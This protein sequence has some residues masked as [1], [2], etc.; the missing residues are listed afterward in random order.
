VFVRFRRQEDRLQASVVETRRLGGKVVSEHLGGLGSVDADLSVRE[1]LVFWDKLPE[2]F[3]RIGNWIGPDENAKLRALLQARIPMVTPEEKR[4]IHEGEGGAE[5]T[6]T[7]DDIRAM[8]EALGAD[9][10]FVDQPEDFKAAMFKGMLPIKWVA[11]F[12]EDVA[13]QYHTGKLLKSARELQKLEAVIGLF[14]GYTDTHL[15]LVRE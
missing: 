7:E 13:K 8:R 15:G 1:R 6:P 2:R 4:S 11:G 12:Y 10:T 3:D 9:P 5:P 14:D